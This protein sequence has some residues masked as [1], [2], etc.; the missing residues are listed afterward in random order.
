MSESNKG[1]EECLYKSFDNIWQSSEYKDKN[2]ETQTTQDNTLDRICFLS[3]VLKQFI[4]GL[5][6]AQV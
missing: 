3:L 6:E 4:M 5:A 1:I 2:K